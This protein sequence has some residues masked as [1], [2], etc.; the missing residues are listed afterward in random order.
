MAKILVAGDAV[1]ITSSRKLE[2]IK[3]LEKYLPKALFLYETDDDGKKQPVFRVCST[4]GAGSISKAG[5]AFGSVAHDGSGL[6]TLT[7][8]LPDGVEDA[9]A[10]VA[11][12][13][14]FA[15]VQLNKV[16]AGI[17]A[18]LAQV[19]ADKAAIEANIEIH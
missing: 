13:Y 12:E 3:E 9:K 7:A 14:G 16:E 18:A 4:K 5:V 10:Y 11:D 1:V 6:A 8:K 19:S 2:E 15:V 17:D